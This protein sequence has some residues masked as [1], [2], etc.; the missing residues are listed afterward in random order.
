M[1]EWNQNSS[2]LFCELLLPLLFFLISFSQMQPLF[3]ILCLTTIPATT[4]SQTCGPRVSPRL[5]NEIPCDMTKTFYCQVPGPGYPWSSVRRYIYEN[6]GLMRRMYGD[7]R[8]SFVVRNEIE[9]LHEKYDFSPFNG[10]HI[11]LSSSRKSFPKFTPRSAFSDSEPESQSSPLPSQSPEPLPS[12]TTSSSTISI[13]STSVPDT[14]TV[15]PREEKTVNVTSDPPTET[16]N[17]SESLET[18]TVLPAMNVSSSSSS[19]LLI[20]SLSRYQV[21]PVVLRNHLSLMKPRRGSMHVPSRKK[22]L[23]LTGPT[24]HG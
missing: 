17:I 9:D 10:R 19:S 24:I 20:Q 16:T 12:S 22:S 23:L 2:F 3:A 14:A 15:S 6:Q 21:V 8:Q 18:T 4:W 5:M 11:P 7:Q 13:V 1:R